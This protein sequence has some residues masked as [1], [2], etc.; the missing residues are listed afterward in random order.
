MVPHEE[1]EEEKYNPVTLEYGL[2][3]ITEDQ[4]S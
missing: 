3:K 4:S 2:I 1:L